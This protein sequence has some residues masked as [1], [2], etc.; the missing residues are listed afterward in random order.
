MRFLGNVL[1]R[2]SHLF[3]IAA[4]VVGLE[5]DLF[6]LSNVNL[7]FEGEAKKPLLV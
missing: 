3:S 1:P 7:H 2:N 5:R 6:Q 4:S